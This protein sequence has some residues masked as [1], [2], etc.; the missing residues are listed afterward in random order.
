MNTITKSLALLVAKVTGADVAD[1][2]QGNKCEPI[3]YLTE[4]YKGSTG[5]GMAGSKTAIDPIAET[6]SATAPDIATKVNEI[7]TQL[8]ARGVIS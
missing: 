4:H 5:E 1:I 8:K 6:S 3:D 2:P 7:I